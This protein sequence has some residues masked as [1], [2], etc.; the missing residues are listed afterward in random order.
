VPPDFSKAQTQGKIGATGFFK[1][2]RE[3][4]KNPKPE[5]TD[6]KRDENLTLAFSRE[7]KLFHQKSPKKST[8]DQTVVTRFP[9]LV[10]PSFTW[11]ARENLLLNRSLHSRNLESCDLGR[12]RSTP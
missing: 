8:A 5:Q 3:P 9:K 6:S 2:T 11:A 1:I 7:K 10:P 12:S 4:W